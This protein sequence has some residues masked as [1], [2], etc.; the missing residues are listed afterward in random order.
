MP[1]EEILNLCAAYGKPMGGKVEYEQLNI[2]KGSNLIGGTRFVD[3]EMQAGKSFHNYY[4]MEGPLSGDK[5]KRI[6]V[7]HN[8]QP[9]QCS[10]CLRRAVEGCPAAGIGKACE[11]TGTPRAK[12]NQYM[13]SLRKTIGY[14]SFKIKYSDSQ[15][16]RI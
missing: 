4:W 15:K 9:S 6:V 8:N 5:G 12:M 10:H 7:L 1:D 2:K 13:E 16:S 3:M 11:K 14:T